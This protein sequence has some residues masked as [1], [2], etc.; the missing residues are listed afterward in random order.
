MRH[1]M[2]I[3]YEREFESI[4][5]EPQYDGH[6]CLV[7][8]VYRVPGVNEEVSIE[9]YETLLQRLSGYTSRGTTFIEFP[10]NIF[11]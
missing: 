1:D 11:P 9:R 5:L 7:G 10:N 2:F 4:S 3:T 6:S 8:E